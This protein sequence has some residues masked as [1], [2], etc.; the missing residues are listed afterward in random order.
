M[1]DIFCVIPKSKIDDIIKM[2][3]SFDTNI[4]FTYEL[5]EHDRLNF[6]YITVINEYNKLH[7]NWFQK[8]TYTGRILNFI[9]IHPIQKKGL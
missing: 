4:Q 1:D 5:L 7:T 2:F 6:L 9:S 3:N 8:S